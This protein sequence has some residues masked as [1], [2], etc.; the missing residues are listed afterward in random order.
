[1]PR[2]SLELLVLLVLQARL[3]LLECQDLEEVLGVLG[4]QVHPEE[5]GVQVPRVLLD[6][7][8]QLERPGLRD[9][10]ELAEVLELLDLVEHPDQQ[11]L[12]D[13]LEVRVPRV[14]RELLEAVEVRVRQVLPVPRDPPD[15]P[16]PRDLQEV[17]GPL[18]RR[19]PVEDLEQPDPPEERELL[20]RQELRVLRGWP[21]L[22]EQRGPQDRQGLRA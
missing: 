3:G 21:G 1:V 19:D 13:Q 15:L 20:D 5:L 9:P 14:P 17:L 22:Q 8:V 12:Q 11:G 16:V 18:E 2:V 6:L 7:P 4:L 10:Q